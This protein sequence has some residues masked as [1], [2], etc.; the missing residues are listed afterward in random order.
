LLALFFNCYVDFQMVFFIDLVKIIIV[1]FSKGGVSLKLTILGCQGPYP[2]PNGACSG[3]LVEDKND[4]LMIDCGNGVLPKLQVLYYLNEIDSIFIS[5]LHS[6]H[7]GDIQVLKYASF[8]LQSKGKIKKPIK[9]YVPPYDDKDLESLQFK[10]AFEIIK[11]EEGKNYI[12]NN[13]EATFFK[14]SHSILCYGISI[15][16]NGKKMT[17][18]ADS[19]YN[20]NMI[21]QVKGSNVFLCEA[22][23]LEQDYTIDSPHMTPKQAREIA[24]RAAVKRLILT[25]FWE[26]YET[27]KFLQEAGECESMIIELAQPLKSYYI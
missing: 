20:E 24:Q 6:D 2:G 10:N 16:K 21:E 23:V 8:I 15:S 12:I 13:F 19:S 17:Y 25:H 22:A 1:S 14:T 11:I 26:G 3:Y 5:H 18:S 7:C 9:L 4:R 27:S